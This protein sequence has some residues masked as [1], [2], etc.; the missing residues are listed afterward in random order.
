M[1]FADIAEST[2]IA[3]E[4]REAI[5]KATVIS[6]R[7]RTRA[8]PPQDEHDQ[9]FEGTGAIVPPYEPSMLLQLLESSNSLRQCID[10][11]VTNIDAFGHHFEPIVD[12]GAADA[13]DRLTSYIMARRMA[14]APATVAD[15]GHQI[16]LPTSEELAAAKAELTE[17][18]RAERWKIEHFFDFACL[19]HSFVTLRRRM[20]QDLELLGNAY[21]EVLRDDSGCV[22]GFEYVPSFT[23]RHMKQDKHPVPV[24]TKVK[25]NEFDYGEIQSRKSFRR[26]VQVFEMRVTYFKEFGDPRVMS[27]KTGATFHS[28]DEFKAQQE[29]DDRLASE[30]IHFHIHTP[31]S[32]YG[33]PRWTGVILG[34]LGSRQA[35]E[36]NLSY[37]ENKSVP[38]LA[39]LVQGGRMSEESIERV[40]DFIENEI[41]GKRNFH[42]IL[43]LEAEGAGGS[44][45]DQGRM[46]IDLK[47]LTSAQHNDALFQ[48]YDQNNI[49]KVGMAFRLPR[50]LRGDIRDFNRAT[51]DAAL[52]F[53]ETQVFGPEREEFDFMI[54]RKV[55]PELGI[56][57]WRF[58]SRTS[59]ANDP[60]DITDMV[61]KLSDSGVL[62][63]AEGREI[64]GEKVFHR[65][66][67]RL[68]DAWVRQPI[69]LTKA[70]ITAPELPGASPAA[71]PTAG[72]GAPTASA[73]LGG[74]AMAGTAP[75]PAAGSGAALTGTDAATVITV[76]EARNAMGLGPLV[77]VD[78]NVDPDGG[79]TVAEFKAKR[80]AAGQLLGTD[81]AQTETGNPDLGAGGSGGAPNPSGKADLSDGQVASPY[82]AQGRRL[83]R[84]PAATPPTTKS[85]ILTLAADLLA[86]RKTM[87]ALEVAE[88]EEAFVQNIRQLKA[89]EDPENGGPIEG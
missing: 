37:F 23:M 27:A 62:T 14:A 45:F 76:N 68:S 17:R 5:L 70:G 74:A 30:M 18:M 36:V 39:V 82:P 7:E 48:T 69:E 32:S 42:K 46:K 6:A 2:K 78:G 61:V 63:P 22:A 21:W 59:M 84:L 83:R 66:L 25:V 52:Q 56:R 85:D 16:P 72:A 13:D 81:E 88:I 31:K 24:A 40:K 73:P 35:E 60:K 65:E 71:A 80:M 54:N 43:V 86:L 49:D 29:S 75:A 15:P 19:D 38:P 67:R 53:A 26:F 44:T 10:A 51:A 11:Y 47:P 4:S 1:P 12:L 28:V 64:A 9:Y 41:K 20:R 34:V 89:A 58:K 3:H 55:L 57:F 79:L 33:I 50:M 87:S 8:A 77:G